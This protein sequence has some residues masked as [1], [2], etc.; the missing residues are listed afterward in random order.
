[1]LAPL[2]AP[3]PLSTPQVFQV[4]AFHC[5]IRATLL[6]PQLIPFLSAPQSAETLQCSL[7]QHVLDFQAHVPSYLLFPLPGMPTPTSLPFKTP[8]QMSPPAQSL[9]WQPR[10]AVPYFPSCVPEVSA[11]LIPYQHTYHNTLPLAVRES[12]YSKIPSALRERTP[13]THFLPI[14]SSQFLT[15]SKCLVKVC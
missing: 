1:M 3:S 10:W 5:A 7:S 8:A 12:V 11:L 13:S 15:L 9:P 14:L 2:A 4:G 6:I